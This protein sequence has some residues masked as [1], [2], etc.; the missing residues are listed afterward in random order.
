MT[1]ED[2]NLRNLLE[3]VKEY[4][5]WM[6]VASG[7]PGLSE[8]SVSAFPFTGCRDRRHSPADRREAAG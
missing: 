1:D 5:D 7:L 2:Y 4:G 3:W 8:D 6:C